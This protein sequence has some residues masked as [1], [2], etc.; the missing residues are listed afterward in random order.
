MNIE[1]LKE[2]EELGFYKCE[3]LDCYSNE[4]EDAKEG[5]RVREYYGGGFVVEFRRWHN[6]SSREEIFK[7]EF[8]DADKV[9]DF[10]KSF[11]HSY[12]FFYFETKD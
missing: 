8:S 1:Q 10:V 9:I 7:I 3:N 2:L 12:N 4:R 11:W 6:A 5:I